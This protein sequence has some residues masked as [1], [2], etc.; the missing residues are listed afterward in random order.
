MMEKIEGW[1][2]CKISDEGEGEEGTGVT[3]LS[4]NQD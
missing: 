2:I 3:N 4:I 1:D